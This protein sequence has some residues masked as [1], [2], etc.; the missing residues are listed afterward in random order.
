VAHGK[1]KLTAVQIRKSDPGVLQDG[2]CLSLRKTETGGRWNYRYSFA[3]KR[4]DMGLGSLEDV[5]L[6]EA[7]QLRD[8]WSA[9]LLEG[10]D[11]VTERVRVKEAEKAEIGR[12]D[13]TL[14][15]IVDVVFEAKKDGLRGNGTNGRWRSPI[16]LHVLPKIGHM[17]ISTI[18]QTDIQKTLAPIWRKKHPTATKAIQRLEIIF[19]QARLSGL[20]VDP[21]TVEAAKHMLGE[22]RHVVEPITATPWQNIPELYQ[23]LEGNAPSRLALR[24]MILTA[25][26]ST[27]LR[28]AR[29]SEIEGDVWTIPAERMKGAEGKVSDFR[30][31]LSTGALDVIAI[32]A[33][34]RTDDRLFPSSHSGKSISDVAIH[35]TM[36]RLGEKGRPHGLRTSFRTWVQDTNAA[37]F[38]VAETALAHTVG[39]KVE[40]SYARSDLLDQRRA[41]MQRWADFATVQQAKIVSIRGA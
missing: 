18:H 21:F 11:P 9:V 12:R 10:K 6:A 40:R 39:N 1:N 34:Y 28:A 2:G 29:F 35:K 4:R 27:A 20:E 5:T 31:P 19:R 15:D 38:D 7:R 33:E 36:N 24:L 14:A 41:L 16:D 25:V 23:N 26:R 37:T 3:G 30:V 17:P 8:K 13:P 32:C 22:V